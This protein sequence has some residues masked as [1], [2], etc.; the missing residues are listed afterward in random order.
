MSFDL[1][2]C[3]DEYSV[4]ASKERAVTY[5]TQYSPSRMGLTIIPAFDSTEV[6]VTSKT[7]STVMVQSSCFLVA[8]QISDQN[9]SMDD[10][11]VPSLFQA[12]G[13]ARKTALLSYFF[14]RRCSPCAPNN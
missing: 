4:P 2:A 11:P 8:P 13:A 6:H 10:F 3:L 1:D 5:T 9:S 7:Y 14:V 12:L